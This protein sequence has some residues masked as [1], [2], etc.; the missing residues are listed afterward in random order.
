MDRTLDSLEE[1]FP[2]KAVWMTEFGVGGFGGSLKQYGLRYSHLGALHT[3]LMLL[4][5]IK[6][7]AVDVAHWH[8]FQ[9]FFDFT[10][11]KQG[12]GDEEHLTYTHFSLFKDAI[13]NS[14]AVVPVKLEGGDKKD[15]HNDIEA[16][17]M[18]GQDSTYVMLLNRQS[19]TR[20]IDTMKISSSGKAS[21]PTLVEV[22]QL[23]HRSDIA[24]ADAMQNTERCERVELETNQPSLTLQPYSITRLKLPNPSR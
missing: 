24:L 9:H 1:L 7:P 6:R 20:T 19:K 12:I 2:G 14:N 17:A 18:T 8:S 13:R 4:R 23:T 22:V 21:A 10:G 15:S 5:F 16:V 11:G 3:D